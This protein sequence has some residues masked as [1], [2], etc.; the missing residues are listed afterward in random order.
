M[1]VKRVLHSAGRVLL[2]LLAGL[3]LVYVFIRS[4]AGRFV[5]RRVAIHLV[6]Q[7]YPLHV[8]HLEF[9]GNL[10][11]RFQLAHIRVEMADQPFLQV[12]TL[13]IAWKPW[14]LF[15]KTLA[16]TSIQIQHPTLHLWQQADSTWNYEILLPQDTAASSAW[17]M[18]VDGLSMERGNIEL[19]PQQGEGPVVVRA[20]IAHVRGL[21][22]GENTSATVDTLGFR[23]EIPR[24]PELQAGFRG[25]WMAEHVQIDTLR[26]TSDRSQLA[27]RGYLAYGKRDSMD[28]EVAIP[29][30]SLADVKPLFPEV[31][32]QAMLS[33]YGNLRGSRGRYAG[34][35]VLRMGDGGVVE[36]SLAPED[37][38]SAITLRFRH[39]H[40]N[41]L[42][43]LPSIA[44]EV[45]LF[46]RARVA[47]RS[48]LA[49]G[50]QL[51]IHVSAS[52]WQHLRLDSL[53]LRIDAL[54]SGHLVT[55]ISAFVQGAR[56]QASGNIWQDEILRYRI[57]GR[58]ENLSPEAWLSAASAR[59]ILHGMWIWQG[60]GTSLEHMQGKGELVLARSQ[61]AGIPIDTLRLQGTITGASF[62]WKLGGT[63]AGGRL[64][65]R[66][67]AELEPR[68]HLRVPELELRGVNLAT[69][70]GQARDSSDLH[71]R[72]LLDGMGSDIQMLRLYT[73][74]NVL[75]SSFRQYRIA[76]GQTELRLHQGKL[77]VRGV[78]QTNAGNARLEMAAHPFASRPTW[79]VHL[80]EAKD[81]QLGV[82]L[83]DTT[84]SSSIHLQLRAEGVGRGDRLRFRVEGE[85][86]PSR[87]NAQ[88]IHSGYLSATL[89]GD[90]VQ[91]TMDMRMPESSLTLQASGYPFEEIPR[92]TISSLRMERL[93]PAAWTGN[94]ALD[95]RISGEITLR[96]RG[97]SLRELVL[98]GSMHL[99]ASRL[100][101]LRLEQ[102]NIRL[103]AVRGRLYARG[104][105]AFERGR[106]Q[107]QTTLEGMPDTLRGKATVAVEHLDIAALL[108]QEQVSNLTMHA[109]VSVQSNTLR[110][111]QIAGTWKVEHSYWERLRVDTLQLQG[112]LTE[113]WI[114]A[115]TLLLK[116]NVA[117]VQGSGT[118]AWEAR[119]G[120]PDSRLGAKIELKEVHL[121]RELLPSLP[122]LAIQE[123][124]GR[125][126]VT[127]TPGYPVFQGTIQL[128]GLAYETYRVAEVH[129]AFRGQ[130]DVE[131]WSIENKLA[132]SYLRV[133]PAVM[134]EH[135]GQIVHLR[136]NSA[137][138]W[139]E[140]RKDVRHTARVHLLAEDLHT[141]P[142][143]VLDTLSLQMEQERWE[144][145]L[146]ALIS[147]TEGQ[148]IVRNF[149]LYAGEQ[150]VA[151]DG[152]IRTEGNINLVLTAEQ[153]QLAPFLSLVGYKGVQGVLE[154]YIV[155]GG[156]AIEP[157]VESTLH[158]WNL[159]VPHASPL[160]LSVSLSYI[161]QQLAFRATA[162]QQEGGLWRGQGVYPVDLTWGRAAR[163]VAEQPLNIQ[164]K[165][166]HF[167]INWVQ[168]FLDPSLILSLG[169][170]IN[171]DISITGT[172]QTPMFSGNMRW[173][174]GYLGLTEM[175]T[176]YRHIQVATRFDGG[177]RLY[178][179]TLRAEG[180]KGVLVGSG[181]VDWKN[182]VPNN[183]ELEL[184]MERF[185]AIHNRTYQIT[186][187]G[188]LRIEG[189]ARRP[190][191]TGSLVISPA[192]VYYTEELIT[193]ETEEV[194]LTE[195][196]I[197]MLE[198][199]FGFHLSSADTTTFDF[200]EASTMEL[201]VQLDRDVW[202]HSSRNPTMDVELRGQLDLIKEPYQDILIYGTIQV[203]TDRSRI[204]FLGKRFELE[205]GS[206][207][208][209]GPAEDPVLDLEA[210][211]RVPSRTSSEDQVVITL[212]LQGR[213]SHP[214]FQISST[215]PLSTADLIAYLAIGR[216]AS[217]GVLGGGGG[218]DLETLSIA[219]LSALVESL[220]ARALGLDVVEVV[221]DPLLGSTFSAGK[222]VSFR[223]D[224][225]FT[226]DRLYIG[227]TQSIG[228]TSGKVK[229]GTETAVSRVLLEYELYRNLL[230]RV[231]VESASM[232]M[233]VLWEYGF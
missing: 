190:R 204:E 121:L 158:V 94:K 223:V 87:I 162:E 51:E 151:I 102:G 40:P 170:R 200:Y 228:L 52:R 3:L 48:P 181:W 153:V 186:S 198:T 69:V 38:G 202:F 77:T 17:K 65:G 28:L 42:I 131:G 139:L 218:L 185:Q 60:R 100:R 187:T 224:D 5:I 24:A 213:L 215:P 144:L 50:N 157:T 122:S 222:Y 75:P 201:S 7:I 53:H 83:A 106:V 96:G 93:N 101:R 41:Y 54:E 110:G 4:E 189:T 233:N 118:L 92:Y 39:V 146:P 152:Y 18:A 58:F 197:R 128:K 76:Q 103:R 88:V 37:S 78:I 89:Q 207:T 196:D 126:Q 182:L 176:T 114:K 73:R 19:R 10:L 143:I 26:L 211:Y 149:L 36:G 129:D 161:Q 155:L 120:A 1:N 174:E 2:M 123:G 154:S 173:Q 90:Y 212:S 80:L 227:I 229:P 35:W 214:T 226:V 14:E 205:R 46:A 125:V 23:I 116:S 44:G 30:F 6:E 79:S 132:L 115:D 82:I 166:Q 199:L 203:V 178:V 171:G 47:G 156:T 175:G 84:Q 34:N 221:Y 127:G 168:P 27:V 142:R 172:S 31:R 108:G 193:D 179:D 70:T 91:G 188:D 55:H 49:R 21:F 71:F 119:L 191:I 230:L 138:M 136:G 210:R 135:I 111:L 206:F 104:M 22:M 29:R 57:S 56:L 95:A 32:S 8:V 45:N 63:L 159:Q 217:G 184:R 11:G 141:R 167:A 99:R 208:F 140:V 74:L 20:F 163:R 64:K 12:D 195:E 109:D 15:R 209:T 86:F 33:M 112:W 98:D 183:L 105:L 13:E 137:E 61:V 62:S 150:Q 147:F 66:G 216:P 81:I 220:A 25:R 43:A 231:L 67:R 169:G 9:S 160:E 130:R 97:T 72:L 68:F 113:G 164:M 232:Q 16:F 192:D 85:M 107:I 177:T 194:T 219:Q 124:G 225:V 145:L 134:V 117:D 148:W 165:A 133:S 59:G 180:S